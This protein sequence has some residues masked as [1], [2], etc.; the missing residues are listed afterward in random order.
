M[1]FPTSPATGKSGKVYINSS[2]G[3]QLTLSA[4]TKQASY[5][6]KGNTY[7]NR[8][9]LLGTGKTLI[10]MRPGVEPRFWV[11]GITTDVTCTTN[12]SNDEVQTSAFSYYYNGTL[13]AA[14]ADTSI[15][16]T[17]PAAGEGCWM[18]IHVCKSTGA[19]TAT[20][21][22][23][24]TGTGGKAALLSTYGDPSSGAAGARPL[25]ATTELLIALVQLDNGA[26]PVTNSEIFYYDQERFDSV[27]VTPL[28]NIGGCLLNNALV[29]MHTGAIARQVMFSGYYVD[30][31]LS[32]IG[33]AK[34]WSLTPST[35]TVSETCFGL[36]TSQTVVGGWAFTFSQLAADELV[37]NAMLN[38]E[39]FMAVRLQYPN[40]GYWQGV[41]SGAGSFKC[42]PGAFN[43]IDIS[44][45]LADDPTFV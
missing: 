31:V 23:D 8:V 34:E 20:K 9:Y 41:G 14:S 6:Y 32:E 19:V 36:T 2:D 22:K 40:G 25:I 28:P 29:A 1:G 42:S 35:S 45:S 27:A 12:G 7:A 3:T 18:A 26:K 30:D 5:S 15:A 24:T 11:D 4:M 43:S 33:T 17:R 38:R 13:T 16:V 44:G 37:K 39:A 10:N 21:G